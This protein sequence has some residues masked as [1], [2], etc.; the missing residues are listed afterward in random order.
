M[1]YSKRTKDKQAKKI[2]LENPNPNKESAKD[3]AMRIW[4]NSRLIKDYRP[5]I[6]EEQP[7]HIIEP[8]S[9]IRV[10][11]TKIVIEKNADMVRNYAAALTVRRRK[12]LKEKLRRLILGQSERHE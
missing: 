2:M 1:G 6:T 12:L 7:E 3:K 9:R 4:R 10:E 5:P 11:I 8:P